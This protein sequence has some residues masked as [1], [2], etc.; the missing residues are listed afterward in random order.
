MNRAQALQLLLSDVHQ[1]NELL[2][3]ASDTK[4]MLLL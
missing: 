4:G 2:S 1:L 3:I